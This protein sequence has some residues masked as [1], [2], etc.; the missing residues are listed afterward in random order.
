LE[1]LGQF[2]EILMS[3]DEQKNRDEQQKEPELHVDEDWKKRVAEEKARLRE[4]E[5]QERPAQRRAEEGEAEELVEPN[6]QVFLAGLYTQTL[7]A[8]GEVE[9]PVSG[10]KEKRLR[11]AQYLIDTIDMLR[12]KTKGNL[13]AEES[14][15]V[16]NLLYDLRMRYV[17]SSRESPTQQGGTAQ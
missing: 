1:T 11:E 12:R 4:Q 6:F 8:L 7:I 15:Y 16:D 9:S 17:E 5:A 3:D 2:R 10:K 14:R 13:T